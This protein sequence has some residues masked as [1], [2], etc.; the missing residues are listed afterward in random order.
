MSAT[1]ILAVCLALVQGEKVRIP[2]LTAGELGEL[3]NCVAML[4]GEIMG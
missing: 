4:K 3:L 2:A 1:R